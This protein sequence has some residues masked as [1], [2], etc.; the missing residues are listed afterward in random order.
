MGYLG[1]LPASRMITFGA[2]FHHR[3]TEVPDFE[4]RPGSVVTI[5]GLEEDVVGLDVP[6]TDRLG[7]TAVYAVQGMSDLDEAVPDEI[8][9]KRSKRTDCTL[10]I[11]SC[12]VLE[13]QDQVLITLSSHFMMKYSDDISAAWEDLLEDEWLQWHV[14]AH[15]CAVAVRLLANGEF[16]GH[17]MFD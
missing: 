14:I 10:Q 17:P 9:R 3:K 6:V 16:T 11:S 8:L 2:L 4:I 15:Q 13:P 1:T 7:P 5:P 12:A